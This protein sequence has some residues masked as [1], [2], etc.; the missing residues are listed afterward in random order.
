MPCARRVQQLSRDGRCFGLKTSRRQGA[1]YSRLPAIGRSRLGAGK[2][3]RGS[4]FSCG[5][6]QRQAWQP[7]PHACADRLVNVMGEARRQRSFHLRDGIL[8]LRRSEQ[9]T[10]ELQSL[11]RISY[12]VFCLK[13][14]TTQTKKTHLETN[15]PNTNTIETLQ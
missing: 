12:A 11:M 6:R 5:L 2:W 13:K 4:L 10:S 14:K 8:C 7:R 3:G 15:N 1:S 9:H